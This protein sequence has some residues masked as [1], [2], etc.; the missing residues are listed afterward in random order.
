MNPNTISLPLPRP[1]KMPLESGK[2]SHYLSVSIQIDSQLQKREDNNCLD[3]LPIRKKKKKKKKKNRV[4]CF[5]LSV[6]RGYVTTKIW[7]AGEHYVFKK[8]KTSTIVF[9]IFF[10]PGDT[11]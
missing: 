4:P 2:S 6:S 1:T 3:H 5:F 7:K 10:F 11:Q 9:L 8:I